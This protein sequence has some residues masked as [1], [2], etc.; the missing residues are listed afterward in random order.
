MQNEDI[1]DF[2]DKL[3]MYDYKKVRQN[4]GSHAVYE[5]VIVIKDT[6][7]IPEN[8]K[9]ING[10]MA[11]GYTKHMQAIENWICQKPYWRGVKR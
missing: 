8:K 7:T 6:I 4:G 9:T 1:R 2:Q 5:R 10:P 3:K 11:S